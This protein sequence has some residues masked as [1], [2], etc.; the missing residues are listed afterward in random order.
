MP[1]PMSRPL[2]LK[3]LIILVSVRWPRG[4][5]HLLPPSPRA[6]QGSVFVAADSGDEV[7]VLIPRQPTTDSQLNRSHAQPLKS[8][9]LPSTPHAN[10]SKATH[11]K[12]ISPQP[13]QTKRPRT[14][15]DTIP[16]PFITT[17]AVPSKEAP[18]RTPTITLKLGQVGRCRP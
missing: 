7:H 18:A 6:P 14:A 9:A 3:P 13:R 11:I 4:P 17:I 2:T 15:V 8:D 1:I 12:D 5:P 16:V 10:S